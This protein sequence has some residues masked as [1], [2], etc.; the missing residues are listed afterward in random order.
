MTAVL[1][2]GLAG[3]CSAGQNAN[4]IGGQGLWTDPNGWDPAVVPNDGTP[5]IAQYYVIIGAEGTPPNA[6]VT[7]PSQ[8][9]PFSVYSLD[10]RS[11]SSL[12]LAPGS[13][14]G[15]NGIVTS[16][17]IFNSGTINL[18]SGST[19]VAP[20]NGVF[21]GGGT[22]NF[23]A[24]ATL[25]G[26]NSTALT[27]K[28][29]TL[30]GAG[31]LNTTNWQN[32]ATIRTAA[33]Q[34]LTLMGN[35]GNFGLLDAENGGTLVLTGTVAGSDSPT[36]ASRIVAGPASTIVVDGN[37]QGN[38]Q[39][40]GNGVIEG[41]GTVNGIATITNSSTGVINLTGPTGPSSFLGSIINPA[42]GQIT[43]PGVS[44]RSGDSLF[45]GGS[46]QI[47]Q[48]SGD[49]ETFGPTLLRG[50]G[51]ITLGTAARPAVV[52][53][54]RGPLINVDQTI[55][56]AGTWNATY[57]NDG[58]IIANVPMASLT[59][60]PPG[61]PPSTTNADVNNGTMGASNGGHLVVNRPLTGTGG[62]AANGGT[63]TFQN[64]AQITTVGPINVT[65]GGCLELLGTLTASN[66]TLDASSSISIHGGVRL[67]GN[68]SFAMKNSS[69][70]VW[71]KVPSD[72]PTGLIMDGGTSATPGSP[73]GWATLELGQKDNGPTGP[74]YDTGFSIPVL[75]IGP[76]SHVMLTDLL[77]NGNRGGAAGTSEALYVDQLSF[78]DPGAQIDLN[79]LHLYYKNLATGNASQIIN[80]ASVPEP[81]GL[82][83]VGSVM[84]MLYRRR[85]VSSS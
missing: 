32:D 47:Q 31:S 73:G 5:P 4:W 17:A 83:L 41:P 67:L 30:V 57:V 21:I 82:G 68:F 52:N 27:L 63:I 34:P 65:N 60:G 56:G 18:A 22:I 20:V 8:G 28:A 6:A 71:P 55:Q 64:N 50:G 2:G 62:F 77:D 53:S 15:V 54:T 9:S 72:I 76:E 25:V 78:D 12:S 84:A 1:L 38:V 51:Q 40:V 48:L 69:A 42:G 58:T 70:W 23:S 13:S 79:G 19:L 43:I 44:L 49:T 59:M 66:L 3:A 33:G 26:A 81:A 37:I 7:L 74:G 29:Q 45:N 85:Q 14:L 80:S 36:N 46:L 39:V 10:V 24:G 35:F 11:G 16:Q 75:E 61:L